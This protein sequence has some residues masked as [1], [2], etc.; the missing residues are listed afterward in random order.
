MKV[1]ISSL[2]PVF[3]P[4]PPP[5]QQTQEAIN[6]EDANNKEHLCCVHFWAARWAVPIKA[7]EAT[8][9]RHV[10]VMVRPVYALPDTCPPL[11]GHLSGKGSDGREGG[12]D[13]QSVPIGV[14]CP[15]PEL[16]YALDVGRS[17]FIHG[18][19]LGVAFGV[20]GQL[21]S[22]TDSVGHERQSIILSQRSAD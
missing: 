17:E 11:S 19:P 15:P 13:G 7:T 4:T 18:R 6:R 21:P 1:S 14:R 8:T 12:P 9:R 22:P 5:V 10:R 20:S 16:G 2:L 3:A